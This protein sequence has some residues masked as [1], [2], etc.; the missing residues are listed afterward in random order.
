MIS[1]PMLLILTQHFGPR[2]PRPT[3]HTAQHARRP[4]RRPSSSTRPVPP[5]HP[6]PRPAEADPLPSF[7]TRQALAQQLDMTPR[8]VQVWFQNQRQ[9]HELKLLKLQR[10]AEG[11]EASQRHEPASGMSQF[12][13]AGDELPLPLLLL[14]WAARESPWNLPAGDEELPPLLVD[15]CGGE[16]GFA[17][18]CCRSGDNPLS[19]VALNRRPGALAAAEGREAS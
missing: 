2:R 10:Q 18:D 13:S 8:S 3:L 6:P 12:V 14:S 1:E 11:A 9:R 15:T 16:G 7:E 4:P 19:V 5:P 17:G